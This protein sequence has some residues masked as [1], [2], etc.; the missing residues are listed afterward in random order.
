MFESCGFRKVV[1]IF[2]RLFLLLSLRCV[3]HLMTETGDEPSS[4]GYV[5]CVRMLVAYGVVDELSKYYGVAQRLD[6][7]GL[8]PLP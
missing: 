2:L 8:Q 3:L 5:L 1:C 7:V 6:P 4:C